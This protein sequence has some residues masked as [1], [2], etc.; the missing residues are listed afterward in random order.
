MP[1]QKGFKRAAKVAVRKTKQNAQAKK[2][3]LRRVERLVELQNKEVES[4]KAAVNKQ[5]AI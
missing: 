3:N 4:A 5:A 2:A 1:Q